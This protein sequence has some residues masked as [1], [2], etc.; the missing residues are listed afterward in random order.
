MT[1]PKTGLPFFDVLRLYGAI[2]LFIGLRKEI[3]INDKGSSWQVDGIV[4][5]SS[6]VDR[7]KNALSLLRKGKLKKNDSWHFNHL[8][9]PNAISEGTVMPRYLWLF[10]NN[11]D[12]AITPAKIRAMQ[13]LGVPYPAGYDLRANEDLMMQAN[14]IKDNLYAESKIKI[15]SNKEIIAVIAYLQRLGTDIGLEQ[16]S[17]TK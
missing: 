5:K 7:D 10:D 6:V 17:T 14:R 13:K 11:I 8:Y 15:S 16:K 12:T 1:V 4:R 3:E 9:E 2:E